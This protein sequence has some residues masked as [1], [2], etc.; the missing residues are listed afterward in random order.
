MNILL[1]GFLLGIIFTVVIADTYRKKM[2]PE[3]LVR[4][5]VLGLFLSGFLFSTVI[6]APV[7]GLDIAYILMFSGIC[8]FALTLLLAFIASK[9]GK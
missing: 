9:L 2:K 6:K 5:L 8:C 1:P 3:I 4:N 7:Y